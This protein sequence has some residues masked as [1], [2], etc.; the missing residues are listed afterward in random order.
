MA[1]LDVFQSMW[2]MEYKRPDGF[3]LTLEEKIIKIANAGFVG[4]SFDIGYHSF[5]IISEA[6]PLLEKYQLDLVYNAFVKSSEHYQDVI[7]FVSKQSIQ[8]RFIAIVGQIEPWSVDEVATTTKQWMAISAA[9]GIASHVEIHRNCMTNDLLFT[10]Q[11]MEKVPD[12]LMVADLSHT[13]VNQE[14]YLPLPDS[15]KQRI[16]EFL[17]RAEAFHGRVATREQVQVPFMFEQHKEWLQLFKT[18]WLEG[19]T[20]WIERHGKESADACVFLCELG[21]P[22]Y[23]ITDSNG[24]ELSDRWEEALQMKAMAE[25]LWQQALSE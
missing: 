23:A 24:N 5:D 14:F 16:S 15:A 9:A 20:R 8:P 17:V 7:D 1:N 10:L 2:A 11:L 6:M 21:P 3:E 25:V 18:W 19:F 4:V 22:V 13:L 12:L